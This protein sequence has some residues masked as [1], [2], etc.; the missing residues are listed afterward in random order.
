M[1]SVYRTQ[2]PGAIGDERSEHGLPAARSEAPGADAAR[3]VASGLVTCAKT[4]RVS[5]PAGQAASPTRHVFRTAD[6]CSV[7]AAKLGPYAWDGREGPIPQVQIFPGL[8]RLTAPDLGRREATANR[9]SDAPIIMRES[10]TETD[11]GSRKITEWSRKS[12]ARMVAT[13]AE[14]DWAPMMINGDLPAMITLTYPG[15]WEEVAGSGDCVKAHLNSFFRRF[16]RAWNQRLVGVW[17]LEFQSRGAPHVHI[18]MCPPTGRAGASRKKKYESKLADYHAGLTQARPRWKPTA[19]DGLVFRDWLGVVWADVVSHPDPVQREMHV[20]AGTAIDYSE[21]DRARDPKRAAV[22]FGKHG[23]FSEK[24]YQNRVPDVWIKSGQSVGRFWGVRGLKRA[25]GAATI[26]GSE[27]LFLG[28]LLRRYGTRARVWDAERGYFS[29]PQM[30]SV[31]RWRAVRPWTTPAGVY[32]ARKFVERRT[33]VRVK[34]MTGSNGSGFIL[35]ND[36][37]HLAKVLA[38]ALE[39]YR[40]ESPVLPPGMRGPVTTRTPR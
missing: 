18:L 14:L 27:M 21:G 25:A 29:R 3:S 40:A 12:R 28:R 4:G 22:Y 26:T 39:G 35:V 1:A 9:R 8:V 15:M 7:A 23:T 13:L 5:K 37:P 6:E 16:E 34:R 11:T 36:G 31:R 33:S 17:K 10:D 38:R 20:R 2:L 32:T 24:E 19:G 30:R